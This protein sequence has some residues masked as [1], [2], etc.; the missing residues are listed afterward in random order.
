MCSKRK[1]HKQNKESCGGKSIKKPKRFR[2]CSDKRTRETKS[3]EGNRASF[4]HSNVFN[5]LS[6]C[7]TMHLRDSSVQCL[8]FIS[9]DEM[10][11]SHVSHESINQSYSNFKLNCDFVNNLTSRLFAFVHVVESCSVA[12]AQTS[13]LTNDVLVATVSW[14]NRWLFILGECNRIVMHYRIKVV[15]GSKVAELCWINLV[16]VRNRLWVDVI[17]HNLYVLVTFRVTMHV[18]VAQSVDEFVHNDSLVDA[19]VLVQGQTL[20]TANFAQVRIAAFV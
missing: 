18:I 8:S 2:C 12:C 16:K 17:P 14:Y 3:A 7:L 5:E 4:D 20:S 10:N 1:C 19:S 11:H 13:T 9:N 6:K 15:A